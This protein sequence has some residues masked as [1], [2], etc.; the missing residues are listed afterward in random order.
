MHNSLFLSQEYSMR[1]GKKNQFTNEETKVPGWLSR[2]KNKWRNSTNTM[3]VRWSSLHQHWQIMYII[4]IS[5]MI[6]YDE[7]RLYLFGISPKTHNP[8]PIIR[9][10]SK[11]KDCGDLASK[12]NVV[13]WWNPGTE[14]K[15]LGKHFKNLNKALL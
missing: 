10:V 15:T 13:S 3:S 1:S 4:S 12:C 6:W 11:Q 5:D 8:G 9:K 2:L 7:N 14:K